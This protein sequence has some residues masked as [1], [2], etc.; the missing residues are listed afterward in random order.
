[1]SLLYAAIRTSLLP[2]LPTLN[3]LFHNSD[4]NGKA[5]GNLYPGPDHDQKSITSRGSSL[6]HTCHVCSMFVS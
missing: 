6:A 3:P 1:M 4:R 2:R 5:I